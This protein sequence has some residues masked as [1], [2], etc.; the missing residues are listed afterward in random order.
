MP[1]RYN[2]KKLFWVDFEMTGLSPQNDE[3][4]EVAAIITDY[5]FNI[6]DTYDSVVFQAP[7]VLSKMNDH[8][9]NMHTSSGLLDRVPNGKPLKQVEAE[10]ETLLFRHFPTYDTEKIVMAGNTIQIDREFLINKMPLLADLIHYRI[11][12][13]STL[14]M[15]FMCKYNK[16]Y[17]KDPSTH[18]KATEDILSSINE[19][20]YYLN[21]INL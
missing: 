14:R 1:A 5:E 12:D 10:L 13:V 16:V 6:L 20:K 2:K 8:V 9:K 3:I 15:L 17:E 7:E 11:V 4:I 21:F 19:L 18:H